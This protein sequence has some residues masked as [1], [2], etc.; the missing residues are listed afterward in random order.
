MADLAKMS[1]QALQKQIEQ[2]TK[3]RDEIAAAD[4]RKVVR[5]GKAD[6]YL[7]RLE[8]ARTTFTAATAE[9]ARR[10]KG[11]SDSLRATAPFNPDVWKRE[12][13]DAWAMDPT[14][15]QERGGRPTEPDPYEPVRKAFHLLRGGLP[16]PL[17]PEE[18]DGARLSVEEGQEFYDLT[19]RARKGEMTASEAPRWEELL[20]KTAGRPTGSIAAARKFETERRVQDAEQAVAERKA[21]RQREA[22]RERWLAEVGASRR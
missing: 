8:S 18:I 14:P 3:V 11:K 15:L 4:D 16:S 9:L 12:R 17:V 1:E 20:E 6:E 21:K 5:S 2:A 13:M 19:L 10:A 22:E 7:S